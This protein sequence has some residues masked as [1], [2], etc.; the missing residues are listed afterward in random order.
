MIIIINTNNKKKNNTTD[1]TTDNNNNTTLLLIIITISLLLSRPVLVIPSSVIPSPTSSIPR[2]YGDLLRMPLGEERSGYIAAVRS[3]M[4]SMTSMNA[5]SDL[6]NHPLSDIPRSKIISSKFIFDAKFNPD[7]TF[8]TY[9]CR[10]VARGDRWIDHYDSKTFAGT[11][12]SESVRLLLCIAAEL[13]L[14]VVT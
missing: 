13:D 3:E 9:K 5:F 1:N 2:S 4:A 8:Q 12:K 6:S 14:E 7:G 11:V 10:L